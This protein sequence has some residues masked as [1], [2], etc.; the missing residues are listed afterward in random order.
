M[1]FRNNLQ[2]WKEIK[3]NLFVNFKNLETEDIEKYFIEAWEQINSILNFEHKYWLKYY[4]GLEKIKKEKNILD[5]QKKEYEELQLNKLIFCSNITK[6]IKEYLLKEY[7]ISFKMSD[8]ESNILENSFKK[9]LNKNWGEI[10]GEQFNEY[11]YDI[12]LEKLYNFLYIYEEKINQ[13]STNPENQI[14][15]E[16]IWETFKL[17][18][19]QK[20]KWVIYDEKLS[21]L[22]SK[23]YKDSKKEYK[24]HIE[25]TP[26]D[27]NYKK[28]PKPILEKLLNN[29]EEKNTE[30][31]IDE[32]YNE[33]TKKAIEKLNKYLKN[34]WREWIEHRARNLKK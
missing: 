12:F 15:L 5:V 29:Q 2:K 19:E 16:K 24:K 6:K 20:E 33:Y 4:L 13:L 26:Y 3:E 1:N 23:K 34:W 25:K 30:P 9:F 18:I 14:I 10:S 8:T 28:A 22:K 31:Y 32:P 7:N 17:T 27:T 21:Y 11:I